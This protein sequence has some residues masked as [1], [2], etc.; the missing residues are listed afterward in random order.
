MS[1]AASGKLCSFILCA[2][3]GIPE[4][5]KSGNVKIILNSRMKLHTQY[6]EKIIYT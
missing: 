3:P 6:I 4:G 5:D 2:Y 1:H